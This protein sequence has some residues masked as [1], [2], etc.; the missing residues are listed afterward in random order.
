MCETIVTSGG[1]LDVFEQFEKQLPLCL[2]S[3]DVKML[4]GIKQDGER[5]Q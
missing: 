4:P 3:C 1:G 5:R 2:F